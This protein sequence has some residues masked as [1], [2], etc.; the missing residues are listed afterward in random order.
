MGMSRLK[1]E[2]NRGKGRRRG[3]DRSKVKEGLGSKVRDERRSHKGVKEGKGR[4]EGK[5]RD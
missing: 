1:G 4:V 2:T 3:R 5:E